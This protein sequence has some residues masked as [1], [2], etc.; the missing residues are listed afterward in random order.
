MK[1]FFV[2]S[3][4]SVK[5]ICHKV[6]NK[7][8]RIGL[9]FVVCED[10]ISCRINEIRIFVEIVLYLIE[11]LPNLKMQGSQTRAF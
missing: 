9:N 7:G 5:K 1:E 10:K 2:R 8:V 3:I 6:L 11:N 4:I